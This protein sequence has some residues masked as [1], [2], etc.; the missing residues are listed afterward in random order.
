MRSDR[1]GGGRS[2]GLRAKR[3]STRE[4]EDRVYGALPGEQ[5]GLPGRQPAIPE[6]SSNSLRIGR[7]VAHPS[8]TTIHEEVIMIRNKADFGVRSGRISPVLMLA[9]AAGALGCGGSTQASTQA[10]APAS[11]QASAPARGQPPAHAQVQSQEKPAPEKV[12]PPKAPLITLREL[13]DRRDLWPSKVRL[14]KKVGFSPT[15]IYPP[16]TEMDLV[17]IAGDD[18]HLDRGNE[19]IEVPSTSTD[20]LERASALMASLTP[21]QLA[22]TSK[23]LPQRPELWPVELQ[24]TKALGF[25]NGTKVPVGRTVQLRAFQG[26]QVNVFDREF[27]NYYTAAIN[28]TD[29]VARARERVKLPEKDREP[30]FVR[31]V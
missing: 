5:G 23:I 14:T 18:L 28:E 22:I 8:S 26:D 27:K 30:V 19:V 17:E 21:E 3:R 20:I 4:P 24:I 6:A 7:A 12:A 31:S 2:F 11:A 10:P 1:R 25:S 13:A 29:V 15:E 9:C 16:G